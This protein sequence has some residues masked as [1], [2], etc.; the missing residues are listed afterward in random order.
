MPQFTI[1]PGSATVTLGTDATCKSA[2]QCATDAATTFP[3]YAS[4]A[5]TGGSSTPNTP[6]G[7]DGACETVSRC[8]TITAPAA[9]PGHGGYICSG[10]SVTAAQSGTDM[11]CETAAQCSIRAAGLFPGHPNPY[12]CTLG[13]QTAG[14]VGLGTD[15]VRETT[16]ACVAR[17]TAAFPGWTSYSCVSGTAPLLVP[18]TPPTT[19]SGLVCETGSVCTTRMTGLLPGH[20]SVVC[21]G[22]GT[23]AGTLTDASCETQANCTSNIA[24]FAGFPTGG[25]AGTCNGIGASCGGS[26]KTG[27]TA[28]W[29]C[30]LG[31]FANQTVTI[32]DT[33]YSTQVMQGTGCTGVGK[34]QAQTMNAGACSTGM[35]MTAT[36]SCIQNQ[37]VTG[38]YTVNQVVPTSTT[39]PPS[40]ANARFADEWAK[41]LYTADANSITGQQNIKT[42]TI[43]VF[44][45]A[46]DVNETALLM[47]MAKYGG[48][49]Y[50]QA[51]S[52]DA[53]LN[54]LREILVEIQAV[55]SVFAA[56]SLPIAA[57]NR[58]QNENQVFI[59][60]F[61]PDGAANPKWFGNL[62]QYQVALFGADA[63]LADA[64]GKEAIAATTGFVQACAR[65]FYTTDSTVTVAGAPVTY[66]DFSPS[67]AG[68]CTSV[69][70]S[71]NNDQPDG[72][73]V[74]KGATAEVLR[75]GNSTTQL[76]PFTVTRAMQTCTTAPCTGLVDFNSTNVPLGRT[77]AASAAI[78]QNLI[79]FTYG[80][81]T[82]ALPDENGNGLTDEPRPSIHG[83]VTHS[84]ALPVNFGGSRGVEL[85]YGSN[86]GALHGI[87]ASDGTEKWSFIAPEH[88]AKLKRLFENKPKI[89]G[90]GVSNLLSPTPIPKDYFFDGSLGLY[91]NADNSK[92]WIFP[93]QRRGG[94]MVYGFDITAAG[95]P[96][97]LWAK[98]CPDLTDDTG[99]TP[100]MDGIGQTWSTPSVG[101][102]K[103]YSPTKPV[104]VFGGGY[105][106]CEDQ[107][108]AVNTACGAGTKGHKVYIL[109]AETGALVTPLPFNTDRAVSSDVTFIDR[110][111]D[112]SVDYIYV[113]DMGG[114]IYRIDL[115]NSDKSPRAPGAWTITKIAATTGGGRKFMFGPASLATATQVFLTLGSGDRE[116]PLKAN[117]PFATPIVN[118]F[119]M[120][121]DKFPASGTVNLDGATMDD[122]TSATSCTSTSSIPTGPDGWFLNLPDT[123]EQTVTSSVIFGGTVF[124]ST[125]HA[126]DPVIN[127]CGTNL[128]EA[129]GYAVNL[130]N[131]SGVIGSGGLCGG[132]RSGVF[133]G[134]GLPPSPV[135]GTVPVRQ[136][137]GTMKPISVLIGGINL[138]GN[139]SSP[140][141]AQQPPVPIKQIRSRIYWY[142]HQGN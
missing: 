129:K 11:A 18:S 105:D 80:K 78:N 67:S 120:F 51:T 119:Y 106:N 46:Q 59:G 87:R 116:R 115:V 111:F 94:R 72:P 68:T 133:T 102:I 132:T 63:K 92:V 69:A 40:A 62:K 12:T 28:T 34:L 85:Y 3:G 52:E 47:S 27:Q 9:S 73:V 135:V 141:G 39:A 2:A 98:G 37:A 66:W 110:D 123:G 16:A 32:K 36:D 82:G 103:G 6:I 54:A 14:T 90:P 112:G 61:R 22:T 50:F 57:N 71:A 97:L 56:A 58:T 29:T 91:Q 138:G 44:K 53:I 64:D 5:C 130:L 60:M 8:Q 122:F 139:I 137:D 108:A 96:A 75:R 21:S 70:N 99:C 83:D 31:K 74:E 131:A 104:V 121:I 84:R 20:T 124:F 55:N 25:T 13:S 127:T 1:I 140:I 19:T 24:T 43:D 65:S 136:P 109:D 89:S 33:T 30:P 7:T 86:D 49:R 23:T 10:G 17:V 107:D 88:H 128:G 126:F 118:R 26:K 95:T 77:G 93:S 81:D 4:Y 35:Q 41:Y 76:P 101:I 142:N 114:G 117:Y 79:D 100:G 42:Y 48:G 15:S 134:G 45:D 113:A 38:T 125:N